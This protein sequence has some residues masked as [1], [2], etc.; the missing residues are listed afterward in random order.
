MMRCAIPGRQTVIRL[1]AAALTIG[2]LSACSAIVQKPTPMADIESDN[3]AFEKAGYLIQPGDQIELHHLV[4]TDYSAVVTVNPDGK[5][6]VP[7][8][9]DPVQAAD[10][11]VGQLGAELG[12]LYVSKGLIKEPSFSLN[13]RTFA[14]QQVYIGGEVQRPGYLE[15][16]GGRRT[17]LQV[18]AAAGGWLPTARTDEVI[19]VRTGVDHKQMIFPVNINKILSGA[20]LDQNVVIRPRDVVLVPR[21][22]VSSL[23]T[24]IDQHIRQVIPIPASAGASYSYNAGSNVVH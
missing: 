13:I 19:V 8:I 11:T 17:L 14:S 4:D 20:D 24:W 16:P 18:V 9:P 10:Q 22:D 5:I 23:D 12:T 3:A 21:S 2:A 6:S 7:G 1:A 15:V